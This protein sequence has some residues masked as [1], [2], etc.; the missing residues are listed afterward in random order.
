[1]TLVLAFC[2]VALT[3]A[4]VLLTIRMALGPTMLDRAIAL[5]VLVAVFI[6]GIAAE[7]VANRH[8]STLPIMVVLS[9]AG[10]VGSVS[11]ARFTTPTSDVNGE[12]GDDK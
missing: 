4:A 12:N 10:F 5:D 2:V 1:M 9:L 3:A 6:V 7:A 11:V 8:A